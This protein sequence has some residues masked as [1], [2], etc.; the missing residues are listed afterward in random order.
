MHENSVGKALIVDH[1]ALARRV[2]ADQVRLHE[3]LEPLEAGLGMEALELVEGV[4][5]KITIIDVDLPD[6]DGRDLCRLM[7]RRGVKIPIL[8]LSAHDA[9]S[10]MIL[11]LD[12]GASDYVVKPF[13]PGVL[14]ARVRAQIRHFE[15]LDDAVFPIGPYVF[16][17][18]VKLL[19]N[20][21]TEKKIRLTEREASILKSLYRMNGRTAPMER[22]MEEVWG[23]HADVSIHALETHVYRLRQKLEP[24]PGSLQLLLTEGNGYRLVR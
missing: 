8:L 11:G 3:D 7:R 15:Q 4:H 1:D 17:P 6:I 14:L 23:Q 24:D 10:D 5:V 16:Q 2:L 18:S 21:T 12:K 20:R 9:D 13:H 19:T 22:I